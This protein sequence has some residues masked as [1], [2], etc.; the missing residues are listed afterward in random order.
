[1]FYYFGFGSNINLTSLRAKGV[2]PDTSERARLPGWRLRFNVSHFFVHEGG[3]G[4]IEYTG[5]ADDVVL[6]LVHRLRDEHLE[7]LDLT[8]ACG[9]GYDRVTVTVETERGPVDAVVYVGMPTFL[10]DSCKPRQRYLNILIDGARRAGLDPA[11]IEA[12]RQQPVHMP[13]PVARFTGPPGNWPVFDAAT[14]RAYP[15]YTALF[16]HVFD[17][18]HARWKHQFLRKIFGGKDMTLF[19]LQR[20]D[21][22]D[23]SETLAD[24]ADDR[25]S[26]AQR[27]YL[28][29]Y[30]H[31]YWREYTYVG[32]FRH[33]PVG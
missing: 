23:G 8:E 14:L 29:E 3:V 21:T 32:R 16:G 6:G 19:H 24:I 12:L 1:M 15:D 4:N 18:A 13:E 27:T 22:S 26:E 5:R 20:M 17:M 33:E 11:Y 10:D 30:L 31:Q 9:F 2:E 25:L 7:P 28:D